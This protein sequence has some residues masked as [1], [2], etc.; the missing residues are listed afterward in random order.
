[1]L[2]VAFGRIFRKLLPS[3]IVRTPFRP[4]SIIMHYGSEQPR[5]ASLIHSL[6]C[7][8]AGKC[9][10]SLDTLRPLCYVALTGF[11]VTTSKVRVVMSNDDVKLMSVT[12]HTIR[13]ACHLFDALHSFET[14][15]VMFH[16]PC[17]KS[18]QSKNQDFSCAF[19]D[20]S[21]HFRPRLLSMV[22]VNNGAQWDSNWLNSDLFCVFLFWPIVQWWSFIALTTTRSHS[23]FLIKQR[24]ALGVTFFVT[25]IALMVLPSFLISFWL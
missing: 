5:I 12:I 10:L 9:F 23:V 24:R 16:G 13:L 7:S 2:H 21:R 25:A 20:L 17:L 1:M 15:I 3:H 4:N 11:L 19:S 22:V 6:A 18:C 14:Y 8:H